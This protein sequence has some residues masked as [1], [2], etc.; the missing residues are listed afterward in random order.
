MILR[1]AIHPTHFS[2]PGRQRLLCDRLGTNG[3]FHLLARWFNFGSLGLE[4][5]LSSQPALNVLL[6]FTIGSGLSPLINDIDASVGLRPLSLLNREG[7]GLV[8]ISS[9]LRSDLS[10][11]DLSRAENITE[12]ATLCPALTLTTHHAPIDIL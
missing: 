1:A 10:I 9:W 4:Q 7:A 3:G 2:V 8:A 11:R 6:P 12:G 5:C